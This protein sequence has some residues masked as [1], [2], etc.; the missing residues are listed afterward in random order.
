MGDGDGGR[1]TSS[2]ETASARGY[3]IML[4]TA[5]PLALAFDVSLAACEA[6]VCGVALYD[7]ISVTLIRD[8]PAAHV[9]SEEANWDNAS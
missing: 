5:V 6:V 7:V 8:G 1:G 9:G 3:N 4:F 2:C